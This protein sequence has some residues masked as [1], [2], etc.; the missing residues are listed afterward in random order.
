[1]LQR[2]RATDE[3]APVEAH[4]GSGRRPKACHPSG[5]RMASGL[6]VKMAPKSLAIKMQC[7]LLGLA[8][9]GG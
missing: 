1:M 7:A 2:G 4:D 6:D 5:L 3:N 8:L 9:N